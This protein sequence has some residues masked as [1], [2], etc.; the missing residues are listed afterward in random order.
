MN[1]TCVFCNRDFSDYGN[2]PH[3][4]MV[5]GKCC[6]ECNNKLIIPYRLMEVKANRNNKNNILYKEKKI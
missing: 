6:N 1:Y 2:S 4:I 3:P 5:K